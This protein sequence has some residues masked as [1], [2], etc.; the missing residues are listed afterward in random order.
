MAD[1]RDYGNDI[2]VPTE[3][4]PKSYTCTI[5][6]EICICICACTAPIYQEEEKLCS[7]C[8]LSYIRGADEHEPIK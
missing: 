5:E 1:P 3:C 7:D 2:N 6:P 4:Q 8:W